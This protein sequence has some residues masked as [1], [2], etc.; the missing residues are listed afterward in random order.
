VVI[1]GTVQ[2]TALQDSVNLTVA[3]REVFI[4][5]GTG[6]EIFEPNSAQYRVEYIV[7]VTD[8]QG[9]GV[10]GVT[11][12]LNVLSQQ[13]FEGF[14]TWNGVTWATTVTASCQ[15]EDANR[16]GVLDL[17]LEDFNA[18]GSLEAGNIAAAAVQGV[19]GGTMVTDQNG[20]GIVDIFYPQEFAYYLRV[21]LEATA[22]VAGT[23]FAEPTTFILTGS[24][25]DFNVENVA[26]PGIVSPFGSQNDCALPDLP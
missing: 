23:E 7:Q 14:R 13:Y 5:I 16:D 17:T 10:A 26:P 22:T 4:A 8:A 12:Q 18:N 21:T 24:A 20:F 6:N 25:S 9:N 3:E 15:D 19:G 11:V 2:G 1:T